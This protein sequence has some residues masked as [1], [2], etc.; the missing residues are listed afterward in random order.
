MQAKY[1]GTC[2]TCKG[3]IEIGT[4]ILWKRG[5]G[6]WHPVCPENGSGTPEPVVL[7]DGLDSIRALLNRAAGRLR[8]PKIELSLPKPKLLLRLYMAGPNSRYQGQVMVLA[9]AYRPTD[10][11]GRIDQ[12]GE[13]HRS[14]RFASLPEHV[15]E[16]IVNLLSD[17]ANDPAG[18]AGEHGRRLGNCCFCSREL[19]TPESLFVGYGPV[20]AENYGLP[21]GAV[22]DD[23]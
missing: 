19:S 22:G 6:A 17:F 20:C 2:V 23:N 16:T 1:A 9:G 14:A 13:F 4:E 7:A 12:D 15:R 5:V 18:V 21:W 11:M 3:R 10:W 8:W